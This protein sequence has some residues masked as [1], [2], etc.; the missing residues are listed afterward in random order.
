MNDQIKLRPNL[1]F[2]RYVFECYYSRTDWI[3]WGE[4]HLKDGCYV[5]QTLYDDFVSMF[6]YYSLPTDFQTICNFCYLSDILQI[7][8]LSILKSG[9]YEKS[10]H[11]YILNKEREETKAFI[12]LASKQKKEYS[13]A[14]SVW[15][16]LKQEPT[17]PKFSITFKS[18][19]KEPKTLEINHFSNYIIDLLSNDQYLNLTLEKVVFSNEIPITYFIKKTITIFDKI[20]IRLDYSYQT[21]RVK[22]MVIESILRISNVDLESLSDNIDKYLP[23]LAQR[24]IKE[25]LCKIIPD[26]IF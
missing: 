26:P 5:E 2:A 8:E 7:V 16:E 17:E 6:D 23:Q 10:N 22:Y 9:G 25:G 14:L 4:R 20:S 19:G 12:N 15:D 11:N 18:Y 13:K 21:K 3:E 1:E 24:A